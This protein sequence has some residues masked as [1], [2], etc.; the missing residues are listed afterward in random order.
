MNRSKYECRLE[1][2]DHKYR[3]EKVKVVAGSH[4]SVSYGKVVVN[5]IH[6]YR[7]SYRLLSLI[8]AFILIGCEVVVMFLL[9]PRVSSGSGLFCLVGC[10]PLILFILLSG[11]VDGCLKNVWVDLKK[12]LIIYFTRIIL[13]V[14][15]LI[16]LLIFILLLRAI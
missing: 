14:V 12:V 3:I 6:T 13:I 1:V 5:H 15:Y 11:Y 10:C 2:V 7:E 9:Y 4:D 8:L 16:V